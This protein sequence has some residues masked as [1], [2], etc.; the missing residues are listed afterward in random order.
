MAGARARALCDLTEPEE[1]GESRPRKAGD[2]WIVRGP[3][4]YVPTEKVLIHKESS[5]LSLG[6]GEGLYVRDLRSG[7]VS[8]VQGPCH[9]MP[10]AHQELHEKRLSAD[11]E[12][13][14]GLAPPPPA[15]ALAAVEVKE[16]KAPR[17]TTLSSERVDRTRAI[18]LRIEDNTAVLSSN[19]NLFDAMQ[20]LLGLGGAPRLPWRARGAGRPWKA[21]GSARRAW[22]WRPRACP[23][24]P[25]P[26]PRGRRPPRGPGHRPSPPA[27]APRGRR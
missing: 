19:L 22:S 11:A 2:T 24:P 10:E 23:P 15:P 20:G 13:L 26:A 17:P 4:T 14:L 7:K 21:S 3:R 1:G 6:Q 18:V 8:L 27:P 12:V 5:A 25:A 9:F 16:A